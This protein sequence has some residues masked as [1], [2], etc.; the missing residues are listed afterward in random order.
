MT[1]YFY[2]A[3]IYLYVNLKPREHVLTAGLYKTVGNVLNG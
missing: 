2:K 1:E 3:T